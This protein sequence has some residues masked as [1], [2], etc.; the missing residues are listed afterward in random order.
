MR[1]E[2]YSS[3][4]PVARLDVFR[5]IIVAPLPADRGRLI[6]R[7]S[8]QS[9]R[10]VSRIRVPRV[11]TC[12][13]LLLGRAW[14]DPRMGQGRDRRYRRQRHGR[15]WR[16]NRKVSRTRPIRSIP[17]LRSNRRQLFHQVSL[18]RMDRLQASASRI[19][20]AR[21]ATARRLAQTTRQTPDTD[22]VRR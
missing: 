22:V 13:V 17:Q 12:D 1:T 20:Q 21:A 7:P 11:N 10:R 2:T 14:R 4:T 6:R 3:S 18:D 16:D 15:W 5:T 19:T 9:R 8:G